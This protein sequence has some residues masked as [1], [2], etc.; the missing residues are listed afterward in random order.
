[1]ISSKHLFGEKNRIFLNLDLGCSSECS[2]CYLPSEKIQIGRNN[3]NTNNTVSAQELYEHLCND[4]SFVPGP[5]GTLLS[6]GCYSETWD[7]R[8]REETIQLIKNLL[9]HG[10]NIQL[11]TKRKIDSAD[12][13]TIKEGEHWNRQL[14]I[15]I[16]STSLS[17]W[18]EYE[19]RTIPPH[20]R[21]LSFKS[22]AD[23]DIPAILYIK[24]VLPGI[25]ILDVD[26]F[27]DLMKSYEIPCIVGDMFTENS[28]EMISPISSK[29]FVAKVDESITIRKK[30]SAF[31]PVFAT[32][33]EA[34]N[35]IR[36]KQ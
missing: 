8:N 13:K 35:H 29:L 26:L 24:P 18:K 20:T 6:I 21:F 15:Y 3:S 36:R 19:K 9:R 27:G 7:P 33:E 28:N 32:S 34:L 31:G 5:E 23:L 14:S 11:A 22:C 1:M 17:H 30:L 16:S 10:N 4:K 12:I 2:Y 25:T